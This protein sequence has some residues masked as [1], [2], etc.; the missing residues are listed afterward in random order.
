MKLV[1]SRG[2]TSDDVRAVRRAFPPGTPVILQP[3]GNAGWSLRRA[4]RLLEEASRQGLVN[5]RV[6]LQ[7]HKVYHLK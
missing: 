7:L 4:V 3:Q 1:V 6:G 2:L 5:V